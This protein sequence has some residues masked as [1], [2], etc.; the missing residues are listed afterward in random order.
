MEMTILLAAVLAGFVASAPVGPVNLWIVYRLLQNRQAPVMAFV[1]G[2][3]LVD[4]G[5]VALGFSTYFFVSSHWAIDKGWHIA[6]GLL[7]TGIGLISLFKNQQRIKKT[8]V[9]RVPEAGKFFLT[10]LL[11]CASN[12]ALSV[13]WF[14]IAGLF[15]YYQL[16]ILHYWHLFWVLAGVLAGDCLWFYAYVYAIRRGSRAL[17]GVSARRIQ[18][19]VALAFIL[20][21]LFTACRQL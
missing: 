15:A 7:M 12:V 13:L 8:S 18:Q 5:Y 16:V 6:G 1:W 9:S 21:G 2:V 11:L 4:L 19:L 10:G 20:F 17:R 3:M 14:F